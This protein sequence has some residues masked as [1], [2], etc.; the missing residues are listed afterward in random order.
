MQTE[1]KLL[2]GNSWTWADQISTYRFW[3]ILLFLIFFVIPSL[4]I[5]FFVPRLM[6][7]Y[8]MSADGVNIVFAVY[9]FTIFSGILLAWFMVRMNNHY[10][11]FLFAMLSIIGFLLMLIVPSIISVLIGLFLV[12]ISFGAIIL[13][14]PTIIAGGKGGSEMFVVSFGII[15]FFQGVMQTSYSNFIF[16]LSGIFNIDN[17]FLLIGLIASVVGTIFLLP[18]KK[19][20]FYIAPPERK[21]FLTPTKR[22][23]VIMVLLCL[24]PLYNI[25]YI[26]HLA[27]RLHGEVNEIN[28]SQKILSPRAAVWCTLLLS[29]ISPIIVSSLNSNLALKL[30]E[31]NATRF[32]KTWIVI[33]WSFIF[34]PISYALIQS[35]MNQLLKDVSNDIKG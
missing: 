13:A 16:D 10:L 18:V 7:S 6:N 28:P 1:K 23:P 14:V 5:S 33:F 8:G 31:N 4:T 11:L 12:G 20:L 29:I 30:K 32:Y 27:Y 19:D 21:S 35:N 2:N 26:L 9:T 17:S 25:Y 3:G 22:E 15:L 34:T 24:I